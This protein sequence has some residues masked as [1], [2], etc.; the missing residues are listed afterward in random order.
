MPTAPPRACARCGQLHCQVH[1]RQAWRNGPPPPRI[2]GARLQ[3]LR[4]QLFDASPLCVICEAAGRVTVA[5]I[6]DHI[7]PLAEGGRDDASNSQPVCAECHTRKTAAEA[8]RGRRRNRGD[9]R[10]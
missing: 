9:F 4:R 10:C 5:T 3:R 2:R 7:V 6:R 1:V 8:K